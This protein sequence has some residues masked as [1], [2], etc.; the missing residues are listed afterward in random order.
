MRTHKF[1]FLT[2]IILVLLFQ[3]C[4]TTEMRQFAAVSQ[5]PG[6]Y[7]RFFKYLDKAAD[8][9]G[10]GDASTFPVPG[11]PY[12]RTD[13]FLMGMRDRIVNEA[14]EQVWVQ[15]MLQHNLDA[16]EKEIKNL[17]DSALRDLASRLGEPPDRNTLI[18]KVKSYSKKSLSHDQGKTDFYDALKAAQRIPDEYSIIMRTFGLYPLWAPLVAYVTDGVYDEFRQWHKT[19]LGELEIQ[20][21]LKAYMPS[22]HVKLSGQ[23]VSRMFG[24]SKQNAL[25]V[26]ELSSEEI[27][28]LVRAYAPIIY[29]DIVADYDEIGQVFWNDRHVSIN[30]RKPAVYYYITHAFL[31]V[32][33][34]CS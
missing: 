10:V 3:G 30:P 29:Q 33:L 2:L 20:G 24:S 13:R 1:A 6:E 25:G 23:D 11:F 12:L 22:H 9:A 15:W 18:E 16:R 19:P 31:K 7:E 21:N 28:M 34:F 32:N 27:Q 4:A 14:Q 5:R 17:P 8:K 26:T